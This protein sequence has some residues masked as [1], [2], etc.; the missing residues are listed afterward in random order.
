MNP[1]TTSSAALLLVW[2]NVWACTQPR[3]GTKTDQETAYSRILASKAIRCSFIPYPPAVILDP[4]SEELSGIFVDAIEKAAANMGLKVEWIEEVGWGT[5]IEGLEARRYDLVVTAVWPNAT[6]GMRA[7][8]SIPLYYSGV[9][10]YVRIDDDRFDGNIGAINNAGVRISTMDG[11]INELIARSQFPR[12]QLVSIPQLTDF[13]QILFNVAQGKA[14][15]T[16]VENYVA[17][18]FLETN[19]GTLKNIAAAKPIRVT[20]NAYI[21]R[22]GESLFLSSLNTALEE[23]INTG[24]VDEL[25]NKYEKYPNSFYRIDYPYRL[26]ASTA[27]SE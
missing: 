4:N 9:G 16:F 24:V 13:Q 6:R 2:M 5:M 18:Q 17:N 26:A 23:L 15:V 19:P 1:K 22:K 21:V 25:I 7:D 12:A 27:V 8:F 3:T 11:E 20:P 10:V 14:D